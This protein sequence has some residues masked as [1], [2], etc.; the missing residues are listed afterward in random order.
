MFAEFRFAARTLV[1]WR[2]GL[3]VAIVTLAL[4][5][6]TATTL[7]SL[8]RALAA[9]LDGVPAPDRVGRIFASSPGLGVAR[10]PVALNEF[11]ATLSRASAFAAIGA[12]AEADVTLGSGGTDRR[13]V[14]GFASPATFTVLGVP[15][16]AGRIFDAS[17]L[18]AGRR[19]VLLGERLWRQRFP[20]GDLAGATLTVNGIERTV[21]G[22]MPAAF[23]Y[24]AIGVTADL[25]IPLAAA[26]GDAPMIVSVFARL[27]PGAAW[28]AAAAELDTLPVHMPQWRW[29][30]IPIEQDTQRRTVDAYAMAGGPALLVLLL[31]GANIACMLLA[32][33]VAREPELTMRR[34]LGAT[35]LRLVRQLAIEHLLL[36]AAG[37]ALGFLAAAAALRIMAAALSPFQPA[38]AARMSPDATLLSVALGAGILACAVFGMLPALRLSRRNVAAA[39]HGLP[40]PRRTDIAGYGRRD[41]IVFVEVLAAAGLVVFAAML[42][43]LFGAM[44]RV[45]PAFDAA[46]VVAMRVPALDVAAVVTRLEAIPGVTAVTAAAGMI[47]GRGGPTAVLAR[48][49]GGAASA[50]SRVP[51]G[52]RFLETLGIPLVRGRTFRP[53]ELALRR[54]VTVIS[55][56][57]ARALFG[58]RDPLGRQVELSGQTFSS[59][60]VI[61]VCRDA[62][63]YGALARAGLIPPD[64]YVPYDATTLESVVLARVTNGADA[65]LEAIAAAAPAPPGRLRPRPVVLSAEP[66]FGDPGTALL[67]VRVLGGFAVMA[68]L[69][70]ATGVFGVIA[71]SVAQRTREFGVRRALGATPREVLA[72]V[73]AREAR[74]IA[75]ALLIGGAATL[76]LT[77]A[78]FPEL[79]R[80]STTAPPVWIALVGLCGGS[81]ALA[82]VLATWRI[83]RL[84]PS[85]VLRR[86]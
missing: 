69:L 10:A 82:G 2:G 44:S 84:D 63:D 76:A 45:R 9:H 26:S 40:A 54:P 12:Y 48:T 4:G 28:T 19:V 75:A 53:G 35:R 1:R 22:V 72:L 8:A 81:A 24:D 79:A 34:A 3:A 64:V 52:D 39:L 56:S 13:A 42:F 7:Y 86:T 83:A 74:L 31:A 66:A 59:P 65:V 67:R 46:H 38:T 33:G 49:G 27:R 17:D 21:V 20:A 14:A 6:G 78:L 60:V 25:W 11:D 73:A 43:D 36:A 68:L 32:R 18:A 47:G 30:A 77:R 16:A 57:A 70:A 51:V 37:G 61:G 29:R 50:M 80:L 41:V 55:E 71:Q 15:P 85:A 58:D 5:V 62:V 23:A